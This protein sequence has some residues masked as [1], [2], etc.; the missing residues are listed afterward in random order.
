MTRRKQANKLSKRSNGNTP[1]KAPL[2]APTRAFY[3]AGSNTDMA[4]TKDGKRK[5]TGPESSANVTPFSFGPT[6]PSP[7]GSTLKA[8]RKLKGKIGILHAGAAPLPKPRAVSDQSSPLKHSSSRP[9]SSSSPVPFNGT[10]MSKWEAPREMGNNGGG[11]SDRNPKIR[12][13]FSTGSNLALDGNPVVDVHTKFSRA[14]ESEGRSMEECA[15]AISSAALVRIRP[16]PGAVEEVDPVAPTDLDVWDG[17][18][19]LRHVC[20]GPPSDQVQPNHCN[21]HAGEGVAQGDYALD[22]MVCEEGGD[23]YLSPR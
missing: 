1:S 3:L 20:S 4:Q 16:K 13:Q 10:F 17:D 11:S 9:C 22:R 19:E 14:S 5:S 21:S 6:K 8:Q 2:L 12:D 23:A 7:Q 18:Q 15:A